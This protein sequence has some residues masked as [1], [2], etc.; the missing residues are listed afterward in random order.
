MTYDPVNGRRIYV[1]GEFT[2]DLDGAGGGTLGDWDNSFAFVLGNEV[3]NNRQWHGRDPP[4]RDPQPR[5][6]AAADPAELRGRRRREVLHAVRHLAPGERAAGATSCSRP[7]ST[8][9]PATC[10][11]TRSSSASMPTAMPGSIPIKGMR[12]GVN[13]AEP[14]VG[15]A[16]RLLDT[17]IT[18]ANYSAATGQTLS[19]VGTIIGAGAGPDLGRVLPVLRHARHAQQRLLAA[20]PRRRRRRSS[21]VPRPSD[22]GVPHVRQDQRDDGRGHGREPEHGGG[23]VDVHEHP[24]VAAGGRQTSK[25][26]CPR[27][28]LRSRSW[29]SS[30]ATRWSRSPRRAATSRA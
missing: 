18:D 25:R 24:A 7:S 17:V 23:E 22:I 8:T 1:N 19:T 20:T 27:T 21:T 13:G 4:G 11:P 6:D 12:I 16:Y 26:S 15:Q 14:P 28:R 29:R 2:G 3:S 9:A 10:S 30:T 5:A